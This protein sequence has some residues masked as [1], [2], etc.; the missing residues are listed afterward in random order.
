[1]PQPQVSIITPIYFGSTTLARAVQSVLS[2]SFEDWE[3]LLISDDLHD[4]STLLKEAKLNDARIVYLSTE[5]CGAGPSIARNIGLRMARGAYIASL[6]CDDAFEPVK[7]ETMLP[8]ARY[9]GAALSRIFYKDNDTGELLEQLNASEPGL[10]L[11]PT[12]IAERT[13]QAVNGYLVKKEMLSQG[14]ITSLRSMEDF[15]FLMTF[16]NRTKVIGYS[17]QALHTYYKRQGSLCNSPQTEATF[18]ASKVE[19][20]ARL[21]QNRLGITNPCAT[22]AIKEYVELSIEAEKEYQLRKETEPQ[23]SFQEVLSYRYK[24]ANRPKTNAPIINIAS[25]DMVPAPPKRA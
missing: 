5:Q 10:E 16:F 23:L 14:Y 12:E 11:T 13:I 21:H 1:M 22:R 8:L 20:L 7:L 19:I 15:V 6:D 9:Y 4:Y 3:L 25:S 17:N 24:Y 18:M 2:Q